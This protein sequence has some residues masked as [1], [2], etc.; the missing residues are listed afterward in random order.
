[1]LLQKI[2][3]RF[4]KGGFFFLEMQVDKGGILHFYYKKA[5][6]FAYTQNGILISKTFLLELRNS[7]K[8]NKQIYVP[9]EG[10][11]MYSSQI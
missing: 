5:E 4:F 2:L 6:V 3:E 11:S 1:M 8:L 10:V 7:K 9:R